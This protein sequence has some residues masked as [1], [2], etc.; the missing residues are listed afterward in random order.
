MAEVLDRFSGKIDGYA[1][2][3]M[4]QR[5]L[6][7]DFDIVLKAFEQRLLRNPASYDYSV[8]SSLADYIPA[9]DAEAAAI[10]TLFERRYGT[11]VRAS[12]PGGLNRAS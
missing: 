5:A 3:S 6:G 11:P 7:R 8:L 10:T 4:V 9:S 12:P 1:S 2:P